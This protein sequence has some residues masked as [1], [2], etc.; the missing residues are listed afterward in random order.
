LLPNDAVG[1]LMYDMRGN[2]PGEDTIARIT[3]WVG[4]AKFSFVPV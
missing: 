3:D 2:R 4:L 1:L